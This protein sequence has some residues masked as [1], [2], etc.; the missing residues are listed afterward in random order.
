MCGI[1]FSLS[2]SKPVLPNDKIRSWLQSRGPDNF[3][4]HSVQ[5][6]CPREDVRGP[7]A[8]PVHLTFVSTVLALRGDHLRPQPLV[9]SQSQ[10]VLCWNGEAWKIAGDP[11][12]GN[13]TE[14]IFEKFLEATIDSSAENGRKPRPEDT[15]RR[16][17]S[18]ISSISGP[19]SFVFY[20]GFHSRL[21]FSRDC[22]G[23]RSLL[24]CVDECGNLMICSV[25]DNKSFEEVETD[26]LRMI[27]LTCI[28]QQDL[29]GQASGP[30]SFQVDIIPWSH[31]ASISPTNLVRWT[32]CNNDLTCILISSFL[33]E[34]PHTPDESRVTGRRT[35]CAYD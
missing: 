30:V 10:S 15:I 4:I 24:Q 3:Q 22:L 26:G 28:K 27:D 16:L 33:S 5:L 20:D 35:S 13:D 18:F 19:F 25:S 32:K 21:F 7:G 34:E 2:T 29:P 17:T 6:E 8:L 23:R 11:I 12:R 1:F 9:D 14:V 31:D